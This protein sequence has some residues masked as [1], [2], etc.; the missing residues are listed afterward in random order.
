MTIHNKYNTSETEQIAR[1]RINRDK[2]ETFNNF[3]PWFV[4]YTDGDGCF[5]VYVNEKSNKISLTFKLSQKSNNM[6]V[7]YYMKSQLSCGQVRQDK[8]GMAHLLIRNKEMIKLNVIPLFET[9]PLLSSKYF[10]Y[11]RFKESLDIWEE[12]NLSQEDKIRAIKALR[13]VGTKTNEF[14]FSPLE[15]NAASWRM[16][17]F[18]KAW[19]VGFIEAEGS[20]YIVNKQGEESG[21]WR[22]SH[23]FGITQKL[24]PYLLVRIR[25]ELK[26]N[27]QVKYNRKGFYSLDTTNKT[28][29]SHI[30][31]YFTKTMRSRKSLEFKYWAKSFRYKGNHLKLQKVRYQIIKWRNSP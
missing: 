7:L 2:R 11:L 6:Q 23:G 18:C 15:Q 1:F 21:L 29:L 16:S 5:N 26:I 20:F 12:S 27:S 30:K 31:K 3:V 19:L 9:F 17:Y 28:T 25:E 4:G 24:D 10:D 14:K 8:R 13:P 22:L